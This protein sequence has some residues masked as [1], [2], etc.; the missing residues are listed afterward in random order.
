V[1]DCFLHDF[2]HGVAG[3]AVTRVVDG[4]DTVAQAAGQEHP[5]SA[6]VHVGNDA[7]VLGQ[8][9]ADGRLIRL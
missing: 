9:V 7:V 5:V 8:A 3:L 2:G 6:A 4:K 1:V